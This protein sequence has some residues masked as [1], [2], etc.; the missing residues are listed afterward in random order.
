MN[1]LLKS[2]S[3]EGISRGKR[4]WNKQGDG[5]DEMVRLGAPP[6]LTS[7]TARG[8]KTRGLFSV[9]LCLP[10]RSTL[11]TVT[12][13]TLYTL[14]ALY[15]S[16]KCS[17]SHLTSNKLSWVRLATFRQVKKCRIERYLSYKSHANTHNTF[18]EL[19]AT[20]FYRFTLAT[21]IKP[22]EVPCPRNC[23][24]PERRAPKDPH[25]VYNIDER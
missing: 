18:P 12:R 9:L 10:T 17:V 15:I 24:Q 22:K 20:S 13:S 3:A 25:S 6:A 4:T 16:N 14:Y 19:N 2:P 23:P 1:V 21:S 11:Y 7:K 8:R 5:E